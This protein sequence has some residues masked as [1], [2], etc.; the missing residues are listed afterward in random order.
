MKYYFGFKS[1]KKLGKKEE[2]EIKKLKNKGFI[3]G[4]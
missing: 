3:K 2:E 4:T 1:Y